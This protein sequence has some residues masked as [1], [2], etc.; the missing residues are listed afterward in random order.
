MQD[1]QIEKILMKELALFSALFYDDFRM[2]N[3]RFERI[4]EKK[5]KK[6]VQ[7]N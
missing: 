5:E 2:F 3:L 4:K 1:L 7:I 6:P